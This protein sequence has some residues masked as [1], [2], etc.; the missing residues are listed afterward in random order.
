M[1]HR[2]LF[3]NENEPKICYSPPLSVLLHHQ[4]PQH[5]QE[6]T[7]I[8]SCATTAHHSRYH[9]LFISLFSQT[10]LQSVVVCIIPWAHYW[11]HC[12]GCSRADTRGAWLR[13]AACYA[14]WLARM[15]ACMHACMGGVE[16]TIAT[17]ILCIEYQVK[18]FTSNINQPQP[19][20]RQC[21][22][23]SSSLLYCLPT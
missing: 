4:I 1:I 14:G 3:R 15:H 19:V 9:S 16:H 6:F 2:L 12:W 21:M 11:G 17:C 22:V 7:T 18:P 20:S 5:S 10:I 23:L 8:S 13:M